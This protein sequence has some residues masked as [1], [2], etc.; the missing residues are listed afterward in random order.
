MSF[1][2]VKLQVYLSAYPMNGAK[3]LFSYKILGNMLTLIGTCSLIVARCTSA[4]NVQGG[5]HNQ[6]EGGSF[7]IFV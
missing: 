1:K 6:V 5:K 7:N 2:L 3:W 4:T